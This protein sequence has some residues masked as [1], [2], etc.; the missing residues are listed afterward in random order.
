[1]LKIKIFIRV[2]IVLIIYVDGQFNGGL[3]INAQSGNTNGDWSAQI[4]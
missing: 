2:I 4:K 3:I 1:M